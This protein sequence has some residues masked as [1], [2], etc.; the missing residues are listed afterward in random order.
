MVMTLVGV[1]SAF[2]F[3]GL[4]LPLSSASAATPAI[5]QCNGFNPGATTNV[6]CTVTVHN[7]VDGAKRGSTTS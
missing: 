3:A 1:I 5:N 7:W 2:S 4:V 6:N